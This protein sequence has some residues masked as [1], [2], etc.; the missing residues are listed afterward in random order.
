MIGTFIKTSPYTYIAGAFILLASHGYVYFKGYDHANDKYIAFKADVQA[1][2]EALRIDN[3]RKLQAVTDVARQI[4][5]DYAKARADLAAAGRVIRVQPGRCE[6]TL[7]PVPT[8]A[9]GL[10]ANAEARTIT[11]EQCEAFLADGL[12]DAQT[13]MFLQQWAIKTHEASK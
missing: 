8:A 11:A 4:D 13:L 10:N 5:A 6:G 9:E 2:S 3:E 12:Q 7:R 1:Q